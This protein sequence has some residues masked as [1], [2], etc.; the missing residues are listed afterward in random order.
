MSTMKKFYFRREQT[1]CEMAPSEEEARERVAQYYG[2]A[3]D[4]ILLDVKD[5]IFIGGE[6]KVAE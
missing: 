3:E 5:M 6:W 1:V 4:F 2:D